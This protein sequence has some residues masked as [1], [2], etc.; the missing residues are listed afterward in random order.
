MGNDTNELDITKLRYVLYARK[1]TEDEGSQV[2]SIDDQVRICLDYAENHGLHIVKIIKEE[3][4]AKKYGNR[5]QFTEMLSG[6]PMQYDALLAYHPDRVARNMRDAGVIIDLL[7]PEKAQIKNMA[8]PTVQYANDSSG[9]LTLAVL[10]SLATQFSEHLSEVVKRGVKTNLDKGIAS[11]TPKWGY[12]RNEITNFY[13]PDVNFQY[14]QRAWTMRAEGERITDIVK[15]LNSHDVQ[16]VTKITRTNKRQ[17]AIRPSDTSMTK[18]F[19]DSF[20]Y[21]LLIQTGQEVDLR[22]LTNFTPMIDEETYDRVQ[23]V[24]YRR[25][26]LKPKSI[27]QGIFYPF[28]GMVFCGVCHSDTP[29]RVGKNKSGGS[30]H[31]LSYRC[32]NPHCKRAVKSVRAKYILDGLYDALKTLKLTDK[33]YKYYSQR[34]DELTDSKVDELQAERRSLNGVKNVKEK[35]RDALSRKF[36]DMDVSHPSYAVTESDIATLHNDVI[37]IETRVAVIT[38]KLKNTDTIKLTK[39]EFLNLAKTAYDKM[40]AGTPVEKDILARKML[41]NLSLNDERAP[42]FIWKEPFATVFNNTQSSFGADERT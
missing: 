5:P 30:G 42:S 12:E 32:D 27:K 16:R 7:N 31:L 20:F 17:R 29:M 9:R 2:N 4:S 11:G 1:S 26:R 13:E 39:E 37:D 21:G 14:I 33:E 6:F 35:E 25:S 36:R 18:M 24:S 23:A 34:L 22:K 38:S 19:A 8:F 28:R 3:K 40:L 10:F 15:Y 41:L